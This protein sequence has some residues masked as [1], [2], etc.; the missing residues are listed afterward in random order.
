[1]HLSRTLETVLC[2]LFVTNK[3]SFALFFSWPLCV[4]VT[5]AY[6]IVTVFR[7]LLS[8]LSYTRCHGVSNCTCSSAPTCY[9]VVW[10]HNLDR[11]DAKVS[12]LVLIVFDKSL[13]LLKIKTT[14][15]FIKIGIS[16]K[17]DWHFKFIIT[18]KDKVL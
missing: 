17:M 14:A 12:L 10:I 15:K 8:W 9:I 13:L 16:I 7:S 11:F 4:C 18:L 5:G 2:Y 1:M 6:R 3:L